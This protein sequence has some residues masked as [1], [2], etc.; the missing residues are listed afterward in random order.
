MDPSIVGGVFAISGALVGAL[1]TF[2]GAYMNARTQERAANLRIDADLRLQADRLRDA[3]VSA[4]LTLRRTKLEEL[5]VF[6]SDVQGRSSQ[7]QAQLDYQMGRDLGKHM[8]RWTELRDKVSRARAAA[9]TFPDISPHMTE[10]V[11]RIDDF[12]WTSRMLLQQ[13]HDP[14]G[15]HDG[16]NQWYEQVIKS[17]DKTAAAV[18]NVERAMRLARDEWV[19]CDRH[20]VRHCFAFAVQRVEVALQ[21]RL[22]FRHRRL[23]LKI[24]GDVVGLHRIRQ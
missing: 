19:N 6:R 4:D 18:S 11:G 7:T 1:G 5:Y 15:G 23:H 2:V 21:H 24:G 9:A 14:K 20:D 8:A 3:A 16:W 12:Y 17:S 10:I 22:E 13:D